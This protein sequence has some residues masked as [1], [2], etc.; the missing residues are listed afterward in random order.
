[1]R[2]ALNVS[3]LV[4]GLAVLYFVTACGDNIRERISINAEAAWQPALAEM[5]AFTPSRELSLGA[6]GDIRIDVQEDASVPA[7][8][9]VLTRSGAEGMLVRARDVLGAQYGTAAALEALGFRFRHPLD[10][11]V[12]PAFE[13]DPA[14]VDGAHAPEIRVRGFQL[15]TLHPFEAYYA[16]WEP[17][18]DST[19]TAH[20]IIDWTIKNRGNFVQWVGLDDILDPG[21]YAAWHPFTR[22]LIDYAHA[23]GVR[24]GF[25]L[26]MFGQANLQLAYDLID[27]DAAVKPIAEQIADRLPAI[28][29]GLPF[30]V[31]DL[32]FGEFFNA[33]PDLFIGSVNEVKRQLDVLAPQ[34][35]LHAFIHVGAEQVVE[36]MGESLLYYFLVKYA[37]P[38]IIHDVHTTMFYNLFETTSGAYHHDD[39]SEHREYLFEQMCAGRRPAYVPETAYWVAFDNSVPAFY[40]LYIHNRWLDLQQI[41]A[42]VPCDVPLDNHTLFT[43]GWEWGYWLHDVSSLRASYELPSSPAALVEHALAPEL[44]AAVPSILELIALQ[45][46]HVHHGGLVAY[47]SGRDISID[48]GRQLGIVSQPDRITFED[49]VAGGD[50]AAVRDDV[51][52]RLATYAGRVEALG[53]ALAAQRLPRSRWTAELRDGFEIDALRARFVIANYEATI[54]H[55][56]GA[57]ATARD[58]ADAAADLM[59]RAAKV[60]ARRHG[61][62]HDTHGTRLLDRSTDE[63]PNQTFYQ[64]GYLYMANT[65][66]YWRRELAQV[67]AALGST[68]AP[69]PGCLFP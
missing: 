10:T 56:A 53:T 19:E 34:A 50:V 7:E 41:K 23:R 63:S 30:D 14:L 27:K 42:Q 4:S 62:L 55:L 28:T 47:L 11:Y 54:A 16:F 31:Y 51:L 49:L 39:F 18:A 37:D 48:A 40:P 3:S 25:N 44:G 61:D 5:V 68:S 32:S 12:P 22:E 15:H 64:Y 24:V 43:T 58:R 36:Y 2:A 66:C 9:Y 35:E 1:M 26:Q 65:L 52:P 8:G 17:S 20:R 57:T 33:D 67:E 6:D 13:I 38:A 21:R 59:E 69:A 45:R 60:V 29:E 46:E